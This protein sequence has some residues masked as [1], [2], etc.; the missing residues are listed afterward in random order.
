MT[1]PKCRTVI[2]D[3]KWRLIMLIAFA[4]F[5]DPTPIEEEQDP[6]IEKWRDSDGVV[7]VVE[8]PRI[9]NTVIAAERAAINLAE[10]ILR[11]SIPEAIQAGM[12]KCGYR[13][14]VLRISDTEI[15]E[16]T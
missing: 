5:R 14:G 6:L 3:Q 1:F 11:E 10:R 7:Y 8:T 15:L 16:I 13:L 4:W 2:N 12:E 9:S